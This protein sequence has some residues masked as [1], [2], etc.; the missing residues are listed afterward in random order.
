M[1][2]I[3]PANMSDKFSYVLSCDSEK[4]KRAKR[5]RTT[6]E[7][8]YDNT[9]FSPMCQMSKEKNITNNVKAK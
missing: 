3:H 6:D 8:S 5:L 1:R 4:K 2:R 7:H 9:S